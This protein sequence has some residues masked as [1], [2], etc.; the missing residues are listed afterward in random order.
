[1]KRSLG[2][3]M[4]SRLIHSLATTDALA[5]LFSDASV[6]QAMLDFEVAL[7]RATARAGVIPA[8]AAD[9]IA[10][11]ARVERFDADAIASAARHTG[12]PAIALVHALVEQ[13]RTLD[14]ESAAYV[15]WGAT[16]Q[17]VTDSALMVLLKRAQPILADDHVRLASALAR[18]ADTHANTVM[19]GRTL[20]QPAT[21]I[22]FGLKA[23]GWYAAV[24]RAW[25]RLARAWDE[26]LIVQFGGAAGTR[27]A[28]GGQSAAIADAIARE[29]GL[30]AAPPWHTDR[31]RLGAVVSACG[32][33]TGVLGKIAR[34]VALLMQAEVGEVAEPGGG[35]ST[36][37]HKR[38]P[39]GCA[40]VIAAATRLPGIVAS[41]LGGMLQEHE[42]SVGGGHAEWPTVAAAVQTTGA[43]MES[44][45]RVMESLTVDGARMRANVEA[46]RGVVLA[47]RV[48]M[49]LAPRLG[50]DMAQE[51]LSTAVERSRHSGQRFG[52][53]LRGMP[54]IGGRLSAAELEEIDRPEHYLGDAEAL[55][56]QL[57]DGPAGPPTE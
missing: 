19:L 12:T 44:L 54:E 11:A 39:A 30:A 42:R 37:P 15:H 20:L 26:A 50:R 36:M 34:D 45:A 25:G 49:L 3:A 56:R 22:T 5:G 21:P 8:R 18:L 32:L 57:L 2:Y 38:N 33:Y 27:A 55:R 23:A 31:D 47:E 40:V 53:V 35:S 4:S 24:A 7:G 17:D 6:L 51:L 41:F 28:A 10:N 13:V 9:A 52:D 43:A 14:A 16:S 29:L 46:T 48:L 1:M